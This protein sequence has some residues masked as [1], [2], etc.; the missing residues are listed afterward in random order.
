MYINGEKIDL[1]AMSKRDNE[2]LE[3]LDKTGYYTHKFTLKPNIMKNYEI[4][5]EQIKDIYEDGCTY[6]KQWFPEVFETKFKNGWYKHKYNQFP[7][8]L[9]Y[10][11]FENNEAYGFNANGEWSDKTQKDY[12]KKYCE[13]ATDS[14]VLEALT[15]EAKKRGLVEKETYIILD[16]KT[17]LLEKNISCFQFASNGNTL[18]Y[19]GAPLF[20]NGIWATPIKTYTKEEA[21]KMLNAKIV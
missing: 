8:W 21:E 4:T 16:N 15:N 1:D 7:K 14:E 17:F 2:L 9:V 13:P 6:V 11:N 18:F 10:H 5:E 19:Q 3:E 20:M 12:I